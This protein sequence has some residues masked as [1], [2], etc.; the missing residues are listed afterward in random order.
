MKT[1]A[2]ATND[3][4]VQKGCMAMPLKV[5]DKT[6]TETPHSS[7]DVSFAAVLSREKGTAS[8]P[9][10]IFNKKNNPTMNNPDMNA[11]LISKLVTVDSSPKTEQAKCLAVVGSGCTNTGLPN[12]GSATTEWNVWNYYPHDW[13]KFDDTPAPQGYHYL[14]NPQTNE[15]KAQK[16]CTS[17]TGGAPGTENLPV[18]LDSVVGWGENPDPRYRTARTPGIGP[19]P[20]TETGPQYSKDLKE[21]FWTRKPGATEEW[22][23]GTLTMGNDNRTTY[24]NA[25]TGEKYT[26]GLDNTMSEIYQNSPGVKAAWDAAYKDIGQD[27]GAKNWTGVYGAPFRNVGSLGAV[28]GINDVGSASFNRPIVGPGGTNQDLIN[29]GSAP[30]NQPIVES[31]GTN[32]DLIERFEQRIIFVGIGFS[33]NIFDSA[34]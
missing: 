15:R 17:L 25:A 28:G 4:R 6:S 13:M 26:F 18:E 9:A 20:N 3:I 33:P 34:Y 14:Y 2:I 31:G 5:L 8:T 12:V 24:N 21:Y 16:T 23:G 30:F 22:G 10:S 19:A 1:F 27:L 29:V 7:Q 32:Q 11:G